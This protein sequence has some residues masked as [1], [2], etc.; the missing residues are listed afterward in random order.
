VFE[1]A[2][3]AKH[4]SNLI[5]MYFWDVYRALEMCL[6]QVVF[7][8]VCD[9]V[10]HVFVFVPAVCVLPFGLVPLASLALAL[11]APS[12]FRIS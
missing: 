11:I 12:P 3:R 4:V 7:P 9:R 6:A 8:K 5:S 1:H 2:A 10:E